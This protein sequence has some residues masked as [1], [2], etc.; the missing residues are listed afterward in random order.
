MRSEYRIEPVDHS[1]LAM[2]QQLHAVQMSAY[3]QEAQLLGATYFP[4][5]E[6]IVDEVRTCNEEFVAAFIEDELV[7]AVS[8]WPDQEGL[9]VN[10]AS[11]VVAPP[12]QRRGIGRRLLATVLAEHGGGVLT[13]QTGAKNVPALALY[14]QAGFIEL[15]RWLVGRE[16]LELVKLYRPASTTPESAQNAA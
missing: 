13:V 8:V 15:R 10:I 16:P 6:R 7:G 9:G 12:Y 5:L 3:A 1:A 4:P 11:L 14:A 2:A